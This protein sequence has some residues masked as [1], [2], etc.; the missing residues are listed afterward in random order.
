MAEPLPNVPNVLKI[1]LI[2]SN[3][4]TPWLNGIYWRYNAATLITGDINSLCANVATHWQTH[5]APVHNTAVSL[6]RVQGIDLRARDAAQGG[7]DVSYP[8]SRAGVVYPTSVAAAVS[9][10]V[11]YRWRGGHFRSYWPAGGSG[12]I[13]SGRLWS[14]AFLTLLNT[15]VD[16]FRNA[17]NGMTVGGTGGYLAGVRYHDQNALLATPL[18]LPVVDS[19]VHSRVDTQRRRL[20]RELSA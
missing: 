1:Q 20:G 15:A 8:G 13:T 12:D 14:S 3:Q 11:N 9:W 17:L 7:V 2:G 18:V 4:T 5:L 16:G 10:K 19:T 6:L